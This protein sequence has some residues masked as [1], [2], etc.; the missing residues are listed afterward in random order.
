MLRD[1]DIREPL[2]DFLD[3]L[4]GK[5]RIIEE[6][7]IGK[8]R[9]DVVM[10]TEDAIYGLEIKSDA[11][12]YTRLARQV[13][14]Y[15]RFYDYNYVVV[16]T[17]HAL[18]IE[19]HVPQHWGII[20]VEEVDGDADFYVLRQPEA[21]EKVNLKLQMQLLWRPELAVIQLQNDMPKYKDKS[22]DFVIEKII[23]RTTFPEGKKGAIE[24]GKLKRQ[25]SNV[26]F[27]RDYHNI[28]LVLA[29]YRKGELQKRIDSENDPEAKA[30]LMEE[31][32]QKRSRAAKTSGFSRK[33]RRRRKRR[34]L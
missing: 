23:E 12:S 25:I 5:N 22:K 29:E 15:D 33:R 3:E 2:F 7:T 1:A 17:T 9:A 10:V 11:D 34:T 24:L 27:E 32:E 6:K 28:S 26:L 8:S 16:G 31:L 4:Y 13:K 30:R 19:E 20:T 18:H 21:N 14:D